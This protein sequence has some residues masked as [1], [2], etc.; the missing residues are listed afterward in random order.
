MTKKR[1]TTILKT[2]TPS[3]VSQVFSFKRRQTGRER[4][5]CPLAGACDR[6]W[7][8][9]RGWVS[10]QLGPRWGGG[11]AAGGGGGRPPPRPQA[12]PTAGESQAG[13]ARKAA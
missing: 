11:G 13:P 7:T 2:K 8:V 1:F 4:G 9:G 3:R 12:P 5:V 10:H 6:G